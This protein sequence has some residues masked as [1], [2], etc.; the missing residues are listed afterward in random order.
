MND[1]M[2]YVVVVNEEGQYSIW[3]KNREIPMGWK[4]LDVCGNK[5]HCLDFIEEIWTD[6]N[7]VSIR[8]GK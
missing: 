3:H 1:S 2:E 6:M 4:E 5:E 8:E 7:P